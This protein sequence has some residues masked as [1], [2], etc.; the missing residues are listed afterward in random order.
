MDINE[1]SDLSTFTLGEVE[2][3][4]DFVDGVGPSKKLLKSMNNQIMKYSKLYSKPL[5]KAEKRRLKIWEAIDTM[6]HSFWWKLFHPSLWKKV[7]IELESQGMLDRYENPKP[8]KKEPKKQTFYP[9]VVQESSVP[10]VVDD[11]EEE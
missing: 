3:I 5:F 8:Q 1:F 2:K 4:S 7:K 9:V 10:D 6:P 11:D